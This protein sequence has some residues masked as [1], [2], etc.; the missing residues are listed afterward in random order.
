MTQNISVTSLSGFFNVPTLYKDRYICRV[1]PYIQTKLN[2]FPF[3][4]YEIMIKIK[5][6]TMTLL[7]VLVH[8][9]VTS[10]LHILAA[11]SYRITSVLCAGTLWL[12]M[13]KYLSFCTLFLDIKMKYT[14]KKFTIKWNNSFL[15]NRWK[16]LID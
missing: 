3:I 13:K 15:D 8:I 9:D 6:K 12:D 16:G 7:N 1:S 5:L 2:W 4:C 11:M 14:L 10:N